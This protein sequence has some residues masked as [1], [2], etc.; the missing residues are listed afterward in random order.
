MQRHTAANRAVCHCDTKALQVSKNVFRCAPEE[1]LVLGIFLKL[2][3]QARLLTSAARQSCIRRQ[4]NDAG[5]ASEEVYR[6]LPTD[7]GLKA[8]IRK[9]QTGSK[10][11]LLSILVDGR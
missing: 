3:Q 7:K 6:R 4:R 10:T 5:R 11:E 1:Y 9:N 2:E 8:E